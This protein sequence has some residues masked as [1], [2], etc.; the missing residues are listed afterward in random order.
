MNGQNYDA[1]GV[2]FYT[3]E[4]FSF[5][6]GTTLHDVRVAYRS[7][8]PS[9]TAGV[10]LIP[11][12]YSGLINTTLT[13]TSAPNDALA[14]YHVVVVAMLGNGESA[15]PSNK[16]FFPEP[17]ELRYEDVIRAQH[18]LVTEHLQVPTLE[19]VVGFSMGGQQ[20]YHWAVMYPGF[21]KRIVVICSAARTSLH[22]YAFLEGPIAALTSSIDY[23]AWK[24]MKE[25]MAR[26]ENVGVNL[27]EVVPKRGLRAFARAYGAWLTSTA[28]FRERQFTTLEGRPGSVEEWMKMREEGYLGWDAEDLLALARMWQMGDIGT[29][30]PSSDA[31]GAVRCEL[32]GKVPDDNLYRAALGSIQAKALLMPC[33]TDQYFPPEDSEIEMR[34]L[35]HG[36]LAVIE[37]IWGHTAGGGL[38]P[39][40]T[41]FMNARI[42][43]LM[44]E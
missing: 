19:A 34:H 8:N 28:W 23:V 35:K 20:A 9:S 4:N 13:F 43:E 37:S 12:C 42:A 44:K 24:A 10:V 14:K 15:S 7:Y 21:V 36:R 32:G 33:R 18:A 38:N 22:N 39:E 5:S 6:S 16:P 2:E 17:G 41:E 11:T 40:D 29:V 1:T 30:I 3:I 25:K 31:A 26:G 27:K